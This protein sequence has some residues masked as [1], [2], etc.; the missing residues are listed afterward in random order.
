[1]ESSNRKT[2]EWVYRSRAVGGALL[3][4]VARLGTG[5]PSSLNPAGQNLG[6]KTETSRLKSLNAAF[7]FWG[8]GYGGLSTPA[9][10]R[11]CDH[12]TR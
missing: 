4:P 6:R 3:N 11:K 2:Q 1:M 8:G 5:P 12:T 9:T 7:Q 10:K